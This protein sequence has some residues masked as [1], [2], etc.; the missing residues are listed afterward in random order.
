MQLNTLYQYFFRSGTESFRIDYFLTTDTLSDQV[1]SDGN[2]WLVISLEGEDKQKFLVSKPLSI[3]HQPKE[4][5]EVIIQRETVSYMR[6]AET[7]VAHNC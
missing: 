6:H 5:I 2:V 1:N 7:A 3:I 4:I